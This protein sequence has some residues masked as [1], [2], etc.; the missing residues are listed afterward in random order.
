[1]ANVA[2]G[3]IDRERPKWVPG[4]DSQWRAEDER[5]HDQAAHG[6]DKPH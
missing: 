3:P 5:H 2:E 6:G 1:M 4:V